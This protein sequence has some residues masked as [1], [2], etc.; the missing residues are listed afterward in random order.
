[1]VC[2]V[3]VNA[4]RDLAF[5]G[6]ENRTKGAEGFGEHDA[7]AAVEQSIGLGVSRHRHGGDQPFR[8]D[9]GELDPQ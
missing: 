6:V 1:M 7:R 4:D 3:D 8:G 2:C 5:S 9:L